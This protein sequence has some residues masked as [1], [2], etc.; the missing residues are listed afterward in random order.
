MKVYLARHGQTAWSL[1]GRHTGRNDIPLTPEGEREAQKLGVRLQPLTFGAVLMSPLARARRTCEIAGFGAAA[2]TAPDLMEWDYGDYEGL[3]FAE[4]RARRPDWHLFRDGCPGGERPEDVIARVDRVI[5]TMKAAP[6]DTLIFAHGHLLR[7][8]AVRWIGIPLEAAGHLS[9]SPA[10][11][12][13]L[14]RDSNSEE[15][16]IERWNDVSHLTG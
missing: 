16:V 14:G 5:A 2:R 4:I 15:P 12:S 1:A 11:L 7:V 13:L 6:A 3:R 8:L 9:L 10:S